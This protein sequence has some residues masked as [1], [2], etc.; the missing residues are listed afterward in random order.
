MRAL[1]RMLTA[2]DATP[3]AVETTKRL[4]QTNEKQLAILRG[5]VWR[6]KQWL[7]GAAQEQ[8]ERALQQLEEERAARH[9][10]WV[11]TPEGAARYAEWVAGRGG[12]VGS[13]D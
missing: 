10:E 1:Q 9:A 2:K 8:V 5:D 13:D 7:W 6:A 11:A 12:E 4:I 3:D